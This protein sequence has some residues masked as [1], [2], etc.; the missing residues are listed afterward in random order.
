MDSTAQ[1]RAVYNYMLTHWG[2]VNAV[3]FGGAASDM[4][5]NVGATKTGKEE[6]VNRVTELWYSIRRFCEAGQLKGLDKE[7]AKELTSRKIS[8][9]GKPAKIVVEPKADLKKK[10]GRSPD[11][12]DALACLVHSARL[13]GVLT[14][15]NRPKGQQD[16]RKVVKRVNSIYNEEFSY[17]D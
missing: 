13:R 14:G 5:I 12:A 8:L 1:G 17:R 10:I 4:I 9:V 11:R 15:E 3:E 7:T 2:P 6:Y 16:W